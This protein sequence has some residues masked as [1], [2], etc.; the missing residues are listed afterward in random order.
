MTTDDDLSGL[1][2]RVRVEGGRFIASVDGY[3]GYGSGPDYD[4][5]VR[6]LKSNLPFVRSR[7]QDQ[8]QEQNPIPPKGVV[9]FQGT[10]FAV[11]P[12][13]VE[14]VRKRLPIREA[15]PGLLQAISYIDGCR[16]REQ[17]PRVDINIPLKRG[18]GDLDFQPKTYLRTGLTKLGGWSLLEE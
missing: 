5:A 4:T 11:P 3:P 14:R 16:E 10:S 6:N 1:E 15:L 18:I 17:D 12:P 7:M 13:P 8:D 9:Q 2:I